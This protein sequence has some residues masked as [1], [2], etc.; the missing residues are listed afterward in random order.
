VVAVVAVEGG[1]RRPDF[2]VGL[3]VAVG[4]LPEGGAGIAHRG[5]A[6]TY[7]PLGRRAGN[8]EDTE[9]MLIAAWHAAVFSVASYVAASTSAAERA[10]VLQAIGPLPGANRR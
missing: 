1:L 3:P 9:K 6:V 5:H 2:E 4:H 10:G 8:Q 7:R